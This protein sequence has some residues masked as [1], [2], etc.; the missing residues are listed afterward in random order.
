MSDAE[1][2]KKILAEAQKRFELCVEAERTIRK[3]ALDDLRFLSGDQWPEAIKRQRDLD[4][5]PCLTINRLPQFLRQ[6]TN[7]QRQNRTSIRVSPVDDRGDPETAKV[8][9]GV[10]RHIEYDSNADVAYRSEERRV[11]KECRL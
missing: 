10:I 8:L 2:T 7:D 1:H 6:V 4:G 5:R 9:Q 3:E 11:G